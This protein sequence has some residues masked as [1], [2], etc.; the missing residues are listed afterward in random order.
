MLELGV[1]VFLSYL[2]G[3]LNGALLIGKFYGGVDIRE[4]GSGNA[5]GTNALRTQGK[6]FAL[7]V[8]IV[9]IGKGVL[10]VLL[11]P[12][13]DIAGIG[14]EPAV[15]RDWLIFACGGAAIFGHCFPVW[16]DFAGGKG[17]A[18]TIGVLAAI[19]PSVLAAG[20]LTWLGMLFVFGYV[21]LATVTAA[22]AIPAVLTLTGFAEH[23]DVI[24]FTSI[25]AVFILFTHRSNMRDLFTGGAA[26]DIGFSLLGRLTG[27]A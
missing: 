16:F 10:P 15:S 2:I 5:G 18:T 8:M 13:L 7:L 27:R 22:F 25:V 21:G 9:D 11:L 3:S 19:E 26:Q 6:F 20:G 1:K 17:A 14:L 24:L 23:R 12:T 4:L